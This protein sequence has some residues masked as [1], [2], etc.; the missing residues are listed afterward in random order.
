MFTLEVANRLWGSENCAAVFHN[1]RYLHRMSK[2]GK[3][4]GS[5]SQAAMM[6]VH[7]QGTVQDTGEMMQR[8]FFFGF[9]EWM[10]EEGLEI[11]LPEWR[12]IEGGWDIVTG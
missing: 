7:V 8:C 2:S 3:I 9:F 5:D 12:K 1:G 11:F 6:H 4:Q 10:G